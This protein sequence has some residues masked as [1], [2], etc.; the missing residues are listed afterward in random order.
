MLNCFLARKLNKS[1]NQKINSSQYEL[2]LMLMES[3]VK[4][5]SPENISGT[6]Q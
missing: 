1:F 6:T 5:P 3:Q 4:F 2:G